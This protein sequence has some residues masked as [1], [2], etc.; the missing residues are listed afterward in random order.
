MRRPDKVVQ[1]A[2]ETISR[3]L[4]LGDDASGR[5]GLIRSFTG[6]APQF[7]VG[8]MV[9]QKAGDKLQILDSGPVDGVDFNLKRATQQFQPQVVLLCVDLSEPIAENAISRW[10]KEL[11]GNYDDTKYKL[12]VVGTKADIAPSSRKEALRQMAQEMEKPYVECSAKTGKNVQAVFDKVKN[13]VYEKPQVQRPD[14]TA[15]AAVVTVSGME[16]FLKEFEKKGTAIS[17]FAAGLTNPEF[18]TVTSMKMDKHG[19]EELTAKMTAS[20]ATISIKIDSPSAADQGGRK[21]EISDKNAHGPSLKEMQAV[22][23]DMMSRCEASA[24][25]L[26]E[27]LS[28][29]E[30]TGQVVRSNPV[31]E[32]TLDA[33]KSHEAMRPAVEK[34]IKNAGYNQ[35]LQ[36]T[37]QQDASARAFE[38]GSMKK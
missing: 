18:A 1:N 6:G 35:N 38:A 30:E 28:K 16:P 21:V 25:H 37:K 31:K 32:I 15:K 11:R 12:V 10:E 23:K 4:V 33:S 29:N 20:G 24:S 2:A 17:S 14:W 5:T 22:V 8:G 3:V 26:A 7:K 36:G 19:A 27:V 9:S 34:V 13:P